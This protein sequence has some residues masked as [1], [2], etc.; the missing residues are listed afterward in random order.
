M[1]RVFGDEGRE[2]EELRC[3][4]DRVEPE[5]VEREE[6]GHRCLVVVAGQAGGGCVGVRWFSIPRRG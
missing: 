4:G 6:C 2:D 3:G 1:D 5:E